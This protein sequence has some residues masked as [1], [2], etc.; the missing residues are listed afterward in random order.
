MAI[1][2]AILDF[3]SAAGGCWVHSVSYCIRIP[4]L[5]LKNSVCCHNYLPFGQCCG[6]RP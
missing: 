1:L 6:P 2:D 4:R 3:S 5:V